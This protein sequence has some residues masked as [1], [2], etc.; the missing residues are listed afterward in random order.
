M[1][2]DDRLGFPQRGA[3]DEGRHIG[4]RESDGTHDDGLVGG[5]D[6]QSYSVVVIDG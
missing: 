5:S 6:A 2:V 4:L 3:K 1:F